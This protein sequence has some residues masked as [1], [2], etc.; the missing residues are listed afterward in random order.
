MIFELFHLMSAYPLPRFHCCIIN[1]FSFF[2]RSLFLVFYILFHPAETINPFNKFLSS[3]EVFGHSL[4]SLFLLSAQLPTVNTV[5][6]IWSLRPVK[7]NTEAEL[8]SAN[9]TKPLPFFWEDYL[10]FCKDYNSLCHSLSTF[11]PFGISFFSH[12]NPYLRFLQ[13]PL[14]TRVV[15][16]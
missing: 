4:D 15:F 8:I 16:Y 14:V 5:P 11:P 3:S 9:L 6:E 12:P 2:I 7:K 10:V 13:Q 1:A